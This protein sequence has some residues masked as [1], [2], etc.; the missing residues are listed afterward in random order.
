[1]ILGLLALAVSRPKEKAIEIL[2]IANVAMAPH[3]IG[4]M[5]RVKPL[6]SDRQLTALLCDVEDETPCSVLHNLQIDQYE[7]G[8]GLPKLWTPRPFPGLGPGHYAVVVAIGRNDAFRA[9][10]VAYVQIW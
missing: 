9:T 3:D 10:D 1:M 4:F 2:Y 7:P 6:P 8:V 5:V